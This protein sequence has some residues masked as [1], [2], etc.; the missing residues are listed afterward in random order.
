MDGFA[1]NL[2]Y[3]TQ[4]APPTMNLEVDVQASRGNFNLDVQFSVRSEQPLAIFG[5]N[6][7]GKSTLVDVL[8]GI[9][10]LH[11]GKIVLDAT[12]L[13]RRL[14]Q[15][16]PIRLAP[17]QR[18]IGVMLQSLALFPHLS[19]LENIA[20]GLRARGMKKPQA[21]EQAMQWL[22]QFSLAIY[23][24]AYPHQLSGGQAQRVALA[25]AL[26]VKPK[27][28]ILDEPFSAFD[29]Q[30]RMQAQQFLQGI[31]ATTSGIK[32]IVSHQM[33]DILLL[34]QQFIILENG[35]IH[36]RGAKEELVKND[37]T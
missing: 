2:D 8:A 36:Q 33:E 4:K 3:T 25:R 30:A 11:K 35:K 18:D 37:I 31:L 21:H 24:H 19:A 14:E 26:I 13:E 5:P 10:P 16:K 34:A 32:I 7:A 1:V 9:L 20:Y 28:L 12:I 27:L 17:Q 6:G 15:E 29:G 22:E 23:A